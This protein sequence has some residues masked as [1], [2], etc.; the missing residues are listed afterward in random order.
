M[1][2]HAS[3]YTTEDVIGL[4]CRLAKAARDYPEHAALLTEAAGVL[5]AQTVKIG[6]IR[7]LLK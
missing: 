6:Q 5:I 3:K 4:E 1:S 7:L 2:K